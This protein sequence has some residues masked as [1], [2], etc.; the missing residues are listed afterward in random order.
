LFSACVDFLRFCCK[1]WCQSVCHLRTDGMKSRA[2]TRNSP[3]MNSAWPL[4]PLSPKF[5]TCLPDRRHRL[6]ACQ[7]SSGRS[8]SRKSQA[9]GWLIVQPPA[10][11]LNTLFRYF[12]CRSPDRRQNSKS[13]FI[14]AAAFGR[15]HSCHGDG[16][17][18]HRVRLRKRLAE[19]PRPD[20]FLHWL[21]S[22]GIWW[23][24]PPPRRAPPACARGY[25]S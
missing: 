17:W 11:L 19:E 12:T 10:I 5:R 24:G 3:A 14:S 22:S 2:A 4:M 23:C 16:A 18:V 13:V 25:G 21:G 7:S 1:V 15:R 9:R 6:V 20:P 8:R